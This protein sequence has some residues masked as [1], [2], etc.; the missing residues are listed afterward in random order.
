[1]TILKTSKKYIVLDNV[2]DAGWSEFDDKPC[3]NVYTIGN[4][5]P[6][7]L[8]GADAEQADA[9]FNNMTIFGKDDS[10]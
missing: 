8:Y 7:R 2:T 9:V 6:I 10:K 1:M 4:S 5:G 3:F